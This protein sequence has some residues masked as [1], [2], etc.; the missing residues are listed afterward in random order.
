LKQRLSTK[1][2]LNADA[3]KK[4]FDDKIKE[5]YL[6]IDNFKK[7]FSYCKWSEFYIEK[8]SLLRREINV[9]RRKRR[10]IVSFIFTRDKNKDTSLYFIKGD[11]YKFF[12]K[13]KQELSKDEIREYNRIKKKQSRERR[14]N[15]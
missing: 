8:I 13:Q 6:F 7:E 3:I 9:L 12:G 5:K 11:M 10:K 1:E 4:E 15:I 2:K 14:K